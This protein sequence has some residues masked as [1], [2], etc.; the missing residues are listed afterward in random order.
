MLQCSRKKMSSY[1]RLAVFLDSI[2]PLVQLCIL[3]FLLCTFLFLV[4]KKTLKY[5]STTD[6]VS[7]LHETVFSVLCSCSCL[8]LEA[9]SHMLVMVT[10]GF[11]RLEW[12]LTVFESVQ[13]GLLPT[14]LP[15][16]CYCYH[17]KSS[18]D[19]KRSSSCTCQ[20]FLSTFEIHLT[21][22]PPSVVEQ[23]KPTFSL[24][25]ITMLAMQ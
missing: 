25:N 8:F 1:L 12:A 14:N 15:K 2:A 16:E 9:C 24:L 11:V 4:Q 20:E 23:R 17:Q 22:L 13:M 18:R 5:F 7:N 3:H 10:C 6:F 21:L 19:F